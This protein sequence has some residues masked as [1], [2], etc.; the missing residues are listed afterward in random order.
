M[1]NNYN[2]YSNSNYNKNQNSQ[3]YGSQKPTVNN[4]VTLCSQQLKLPLSIEYANADVYL[5]TGKAYKFASE[6]KDIPSSQ[7]RKILDEVKGVLFTMQNA[8]ILTDEIKSK[9]FMIVPMTAYVYGRYKNYK[10]LY[11][12][13][14]NHLNNE[15]IKSFADIKAFDKLYTCIIAYHKTLSSK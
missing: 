4:P 13:V 3:Y 5:P 8:N 12:F 1:G 6:L 15:T 9:L 2:G 7:M 14:R 10:N 11:D